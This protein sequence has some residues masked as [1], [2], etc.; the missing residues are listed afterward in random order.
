MKPILITLILALAGHLHAGSFT[1]PNVEYSYA[2]VYLFNTGEEAARD[3]PEFS[4]YREGIYAASK[5]GDGWEFS[6]ELNSQMNAIFAKGVDMLAAGLSG[7]Y[8][9]RH[10]IIYF[11]KTGKPV[12][13]ASICF[14]CQRIVFWSIQKLPEFSTNLSEKEIPRAEKQMA[15][16]E[17]LLVK[18]NIPVFKNTAQYTDLIAKADSSYSNN[19][20]II[21]DYT[22]T[23][24]FGQRYVSVTEFKSWILNPDFK[25][26]ESTETTFSQREGDTHSWDYL[27]LTSNSGTKITFSGTTVESALQEVVIRDP[28]IRLPNG[29]SVGMSL[30]QVQNTFVVWDGIAWPAS[31]VVNYKDANLRY[32]FKNRTLVEIELVML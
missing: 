31:I 10:G 23:S 5:L 28:E 20:E 16:L 29:I 15:E 26:K 18:N 14:E 7:C 30:E 8:I 22:K 17:N 9:P 4:I 12:A 27:V 11:D 21:F 6:A 1:F 2:R 19:G 3:R 32:K 24:A 13:S 25:L